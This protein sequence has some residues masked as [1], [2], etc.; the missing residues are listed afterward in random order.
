MRR[1]S[2]LASLRSRVDLDIV[3]LGPQDQV[4]YATLMSRRFSREMGLRGTL[5]S[6]EAA[7][8]AWAER[9][10][11]VAVID[12]ADGRRVLARRAPNVRIVTTLDVLKRAVEVALIDETD[13]RGLYQSMRDEAYRGPDW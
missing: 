5:A 1:Y 9:R 6:G 11:C 13:A 4:A 3:D 7:V 10:D 12:E 2:L 8:I